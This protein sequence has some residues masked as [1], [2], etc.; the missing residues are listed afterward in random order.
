MNLNRNVF[1]LRYFAVIYEGKNARV[2]ESDCV[3]KMCIILPRP[4]CF[5]LGLDRSCIITELFKFPAAARAQ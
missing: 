3:L 1:K 2:R 5:S 4:V